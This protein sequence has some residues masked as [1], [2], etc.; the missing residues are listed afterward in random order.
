MFAIAYDERLYMYVEIHSR[1]E[2]NENSQGKTSSMNVEDL[3]IEVS[4]SRPKYLGQPPWHLEIEAKE[5]EE[6]SDGSRSE[7]YGYKAVNRTL[8]LRLTPFDLNQL[9]EKAIA[10]GLIQLAHRVRVWV[11][12]HAF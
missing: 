5:Y 3:R 1:S 2:V 8:R 12:S 10:E 4:R 11:N 6:L 7:G 9:L